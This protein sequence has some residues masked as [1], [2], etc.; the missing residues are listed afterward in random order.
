MAPQSKAGTT[1]PLPFMP[2]PA[3][4]PAPSGTGALALGSVG[5]WGRTLERPLVPWL[6]ATPSDA[7]IVPYWPLAAIAGG[8]AAVLLRRRVSAILRRRRRQCAACGYDLRGS[9]DGGRCPECGHEMPASAAT[10][11]TRN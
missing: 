8:Y 3:T 6:N 11:A 5:P 2:L 9:P 1:A 7:L 10:V 4:A